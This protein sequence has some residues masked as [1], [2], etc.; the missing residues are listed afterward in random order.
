MHRV[1]LLF[2]SFN[3]VHIGHLALANDMLATQHLHEIWF[4]VSP[5]NPFKFRHQLVDG[6]H[7]VKMVEIAIAKTPGYRV[8]DIELNMPLPSY[9][10]D[11][12]EQLQRNY[13]N[14]HFSIIMGSDNLLHMSQWK[15]AKKIMHNY[16]VLV[17]P[18]PGAAITGEF[19]NKNIVVTQS[20]ILDIS[21]THIRQMI[22]SGKRVDF[23]LPQGVYSYI[24]QQQLYGAMQT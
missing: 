17:Y 4:V 20:P 24:C 16:Q 6:K 12:L 18:R 9:T 8:C 1:G 7:R 11:T 19:L 14:H 22:A 5:Q 23:L 2:G 13:S 15:E 10:I 3:P 21:S